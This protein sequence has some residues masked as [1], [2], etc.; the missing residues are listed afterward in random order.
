MKV[1]HGSKDSDGREEIHNVRKTIAVEGFLEGASLVIPCEQKVDE[2]DDGTFEFRST[3]GV[4]S[5]GRK[6]LPNDRLANVGSDEKRD[7]GTKT[8]A[9][10]EELIEEDDD[11]GGRNELKDKEKTDTRAERGGGAVKTSQDV[12]GSLSK[13]D[14]HGE[15]CVA[16]VAGLVRKTTKCLHFWAA[17]NKARSSLRLKSTSIN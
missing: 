10:G 9:L 2:G 14:N 6:G 8:V 15:H 4:D 5:V 7:T 12:N 13:G 11:E 17:P 1:N 16:L 3:T